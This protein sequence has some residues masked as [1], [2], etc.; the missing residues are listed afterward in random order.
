[1]SFER[2]YKDQYNFGVMD[3]EQYGREQ[4]KMAIAER[5]KAKG[6]SDEETAEMLGITHEK[7]KAILNADKAHE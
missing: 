7:L 3:G 1:M 2:Y 5:L 6:M 4:E